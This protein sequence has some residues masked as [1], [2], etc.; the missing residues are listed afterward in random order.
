MAEKKPFKEPIL[1]KYE[2]KLDQ[3]T[4]NTQLGS[5]CDIKPTRTKRRSRRFRH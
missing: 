4:K 1:M 5:N 3:V 2:E